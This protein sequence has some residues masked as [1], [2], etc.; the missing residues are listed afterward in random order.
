[1]SIS[2]RVGR[3]ADIEAIIEA[4]SAMA[5]ES[6]DLA[7]DPGKLRK[8]VLGVFEKPARGT[9][10][11]AEIKGH[12]AGMLL[13]VPEWSDWRNRDIWWI[14]SVYTWPEYR[15]QGVFKALYQHLHQQVLG[16]ENLGGLR[17]YV[18]TENTRAQ[19]V[20]KKMGMRDDHY[21]M[22]EWLK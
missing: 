12:P 22:Y 3:Q 18:E 5:M 19:Q 2:V 8:G 21:L 9:Y 6:E 13:V 4:Q 10:W 17:L 7:L 16:D 15:G 1:M 11:I 20:Y 14:H